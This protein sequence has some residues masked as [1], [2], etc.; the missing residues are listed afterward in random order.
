MMS[1]M[2]FI[3]YVHVFVLIVIEVS[4][5]TQVRMTIFLVQYI[6]LYILY[7]YVAKGAY[8]LLKEFV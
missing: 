2:K 8:R 3:L 4:P 5:K 7:V 6:V 1:L